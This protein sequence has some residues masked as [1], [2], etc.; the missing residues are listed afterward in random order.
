MDISGYGNTT[1]EAGQPIPNNHEGWG[2]LDLASAVNGTNRALVDDHILTTGKTD[3][4]TFTATGSATPLKVSL[5]WSDYPGSTSASVQ[6]V[7]NLN[8][9]VTAPNGT[10][11]YWGNRFNNG[12]STTG[13]SADTLNNVENIYIQ[14][15][16]TGQWK[17]EVV[18]AN[19]PHG[20][21]PYALVVRGQGTLASPPPI[22][23]NYVYLPVIIKAPSGPA[24]FWK[25]ATGDEFYVTADKANVNKFAI[26]VSTSCGNYKITHNK[27]EP[28]SNNSFSFTGSFYASG[29]F[30]STTTASGTDGLN[31]FYI[32]G[33]GY[34]NGGPWN[35]SATWQNSNQPT[36]YSA[37][38]VEP[39]G[40]ELISDVDAAKSGITV[41]RV[42]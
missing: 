37:Q 21:Q 30:N 10:T 42:E 8:L 27:L 33:C 32:S 4:Y 34:I 7:N 19:I 24:G 39:D 6:L 1:Q 15:P 3:V 31:N 35:W 22:S 23:I 26:Y 9:K 11:T 13:G 18:G 38:V 12:W 41:T 40:A 20:P 5:V 29:T 17:I 28:I 25:S 16:A 2:R 36:F 14:S